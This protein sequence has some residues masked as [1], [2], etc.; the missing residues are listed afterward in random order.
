MRASRCLR[1]RG[2][3]LTRLVAGPTPRKL[4]G[5]LGCAYGR[6]KIITLSRVASP[7][8]E[9]FYLFSRLDTFGDYLQFEALAQ[10]DDR[11]NYGGGIRIGT[12]VLNKR[13]V[14][15]QGVDRKQHQMI[16]ARVARSE[17]VHC[18]TDA[19]GT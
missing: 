18:K 2:R 16:E 6:T 13:L 5:H 7:Q 4:F 14:Y 19:V 8:R 1:S 11:G 3:R 10:L 17:V 12:H 15:L 9:K